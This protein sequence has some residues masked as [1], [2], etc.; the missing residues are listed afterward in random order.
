M[1]SKNKQL[2]P[3]QAKMHHNDTQHSHCICRLQW[4]HVLG[5]QGLESLKQASSVQLVQDT[6]GCLWNPWTH[7]SPTS[8]V[9]PVMTPNAPNLDVAGS[10]KPGMVI[11]GHP[12][13][14]GHQ[15]TSECQTRTGP[16]PNILNKLKFGNFHGLNSF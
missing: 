4:H 16:T 9:T 10:P 6:P 7:L 8:A 5:P 3:Q 12:A 1:R 15:R 14:T 11:Y 2:S 13:G